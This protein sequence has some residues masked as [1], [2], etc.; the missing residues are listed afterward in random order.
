MKKHDRDD[1]EDEKTTVA[2]SFSRPSLRGLRARMPSARLL[3]ACVLLAG[4]LAAPH[5]LPSITAEGSPYEIGVAIGAAFKS[6][7]HKSVGLV[8][9]STKCAHSPTHSNAGTWPRASCRRC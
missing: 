2:L 6:T 4:A 9:A 3:L 1:N 5:N 8:V 7:I